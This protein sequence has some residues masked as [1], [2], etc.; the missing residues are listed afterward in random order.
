MKNKYVRFIVSIIIPQL[1]GGI[2]SIFTSSKIPTWYASIQKPALNPPNWVFGP[3]WTTLFLLM[4]I[5]FYIVWTKGRQGTNIKAATAIFIVQL[6]VNTFWSIAFFN[7]QSPFLALGVIAVLWILIL[8]NIVL[9]YR[10]SKT[11][12]LLLIPYLLWV[13]F[14]TY[15]N[16]SIWRLN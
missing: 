8:I 12:G 2:G 9:F 3:V 13:S 15:L 11:A 14:A 6:I 16:Y 4:G 5:A 1:A 7:F 10:V